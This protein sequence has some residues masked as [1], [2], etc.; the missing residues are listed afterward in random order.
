MA[1]GPPDR[2][3]SVERVS[4]KDRKKLRWAH[5]SSVEVNS[6]LN[7]LL[8]NTVV[9]LPG[10]LRPGQRD[11]AQHQRQ[12]QAQEAGIVLYPLG[13]NPLHQKDSDSTP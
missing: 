9:A 8:E 2:S 3:L 11:P 12:E 6:A 13:R 4:T 10:E 5:V 7:G 1:I